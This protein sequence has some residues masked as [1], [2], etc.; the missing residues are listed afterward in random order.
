[1]PLEKVRVQNFQ[2]LEDTTVELGTLTVIVGPNDHGKSAFFRAVRAAAEAKAGQ[3]FIK[4][5]KTLSRVTLWV[6]GQELTWEKGASTNKYVLNGIAFDR[7]G[8]STPPEIAELLGMSVVEFDRDLKLNL[9]FADQDDPPF[10]IPYPGGITASKVAKVLGDL[11]NLSVLFRAVGEADVRRKREEG[12]AKV[13]SSDANDLRAQLTQFDGLE[14]REQAVVSMEQ[15]L[16]LVPP[17][18]ERL[19]M[20][21]SFKAERERLR[22]THE[23]IKQK[24]E[25][26]PPDLTSDLAEVQALMERRDLLV[27]FKAELDRHRATKASIDEAKK[28]ADASIE[29]AKTDLEKLTL[30]LGVCP[31]CGQEMTSDHRPTPAAHS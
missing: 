29:L 7:I 10:L 27:S 28:S 30:D 1:V 23:L 14:L 8:T 5:G 31:L 4:R 13:R 20:Y 19:V 26:L 11:T 24:K 25:A 18:R 9:N 2:S 6:D 21:N 16:A 22:E 17:L 12:E 15:T 3:D